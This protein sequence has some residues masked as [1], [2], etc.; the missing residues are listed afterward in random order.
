MGAACATATERDHTTIAR[1][2]STPVQLTTAR[3]IAGRVT[4]YLHRARVLNREAGAT[5]SRRGFPFCCWLITP[6]STRKAPRG[7]PREAMHRWEAATSEG[8]P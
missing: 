3:G 1:S 6:A 8:G 7:G 4:P 5:V 2:P